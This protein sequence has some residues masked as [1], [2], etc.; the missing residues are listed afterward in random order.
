MNN[1][2]ISNHIFHNFDVSVVM[3]FFRKMKEF[4]QVL[5][6]NAYY[7]QRNGIEVVI[8]MD[9]DS[10]Q[11]ELLAFIK[12]YPFINWKV[13]ANPTKH[14]WRNPT[15][16][17]NVGIRHAS[18]KYIMVCSPESQ[19]YSDA[20]YLMR[21]T[22]EYYDGH[23]AI[24]TVAFAMEEDIKAN[25]L[26][27]LMPYGSIMAKTFDLKAIGGYD[28]S[29][30]DW[31][32]DDDNIRARLE[33]SDIRK[34][35]LPDVR[36]IHRE[37]N[38][39]A[40]L[41]RFYRNQALSPRKEF[42]LRYPLRAKV[43]N[44][45]WGNDFNNVVYNWRQNRFAAEMI[46][47]YLNQFECYHIRDHKV[48]QQSYSR[49]VLAQS[50]NESEH[51][52]SYL[53]N[54]GFYFDG[55]ILLDDGSEDDTYETAEHPKLLIKAKKRRECFND[56]ENRNILLDIASFVPA[57]WFCFIDIDERVSSVFCDFDSITSNREIDTVILK[58]VHIWNKDLDAYNADYPSS[59]NGI[60]NRLKMFRNIGHCKIITDK[61]KLHF[62]QV[63]YKSKMLFSNILLLHYGMDDEIKRES[64]YKRYRDEDLEK[65]QVSYEHIINEHP[66]LLKVSDIFLQNGKLS[67]PELSNSAIIRSSKRIAFT[68]DDLP[69]GEEICHL[70]LQ[71]LEESKVKAIGFVVGNMI[72]EK[73][74]YEDRID[75]LWQW[76]KHGHLLANHTYSHLPLSKLSLNEFEKDVIR[77]KEILAPFMEGSP[78]NYSFFRFP[79]LDYGNSAE[80]RSRAMTFLYEHSYTVVPVTI[81]TKDYIFNTLFSSALQNNDHDGMQYILEEYLAYTKAIIWFREHQAI[82]LAGKYL[83][84][85]MLVHANRINA[86]C[87]NKIIEL[88][89]KQGYEFVPLHEVLNEP[90]Y[91]HGSAIINNENLLSWEVEMGNK[92]FTR[93]SYPHINPKILEIYNNSL[94]S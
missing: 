39:E 54:M 42:R 33:F 43:N 16:A 79:Y 82:Q 58:M 85:I 55:I 21:K 38:R 31:G 72:D 35:F 13:I 83:G 49:I 45:T 30:S 22:L 57:D 78:I 66:R 47:N 32:G 60:Q 24:G 64:K 8:A 51:I 65:D 56:L 28:E 61:K 86:Y 15:K 92:E 75:F 40:I 46:E 71:H 3:P 91:R 68:I 5:P 1:L 53:N 90:I 93:V 69:V 87:L 74:E 41:K 89:R 44:D 4:R 23:F 20:I 84:Q 14:E 37:L 2:T 76:K 62:D 81:D 12:Q 17:I 18:K 6:L 34:L 7:F 25:R 27:F 59:D 94:S 63:P 73:G 52:Q 26:S 70:L 29:L 36:L 67:N 88:A 48:F 50:Y 19:F 11:E 80:Q 9:E 10:E 77:N